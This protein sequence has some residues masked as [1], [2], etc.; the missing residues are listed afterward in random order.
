[1]SMELRFADLLSPNQLEVGDLVKIEEQYLTIDSI[2]ETNEGYNLVLLDDFDDEI[3][4][5]VSDDAKIELY[6]FVE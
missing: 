5:F 1:M 6:V 3:E 2:S 4:Y